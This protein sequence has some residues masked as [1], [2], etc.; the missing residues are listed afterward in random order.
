MATKKAVKERRFR[1]REQ[2]RKHFEGPMRAFIQEKYSLIYEEYKA[3]YQVLCQNH[4]ETR[5]LTKTCT[6]KTWVSSLKH[7]QPSN[8]LAT[9]LRQALGQEEVP[10]SDGQQS[11]DQ[12]TDQQSDDESTGQQSTNNENVASN[13][14]GQ[15]IQYVTITNRER[16][17]ETGE[18]T[19]VILSINELAN[20][21]ENVE[22]QVDG[23]ME[24]LARDEALANVLN[25]PVDEPVDEGI[26]LDPLDDIDLDLDVE[27][28]DF[29][30]EVESCDW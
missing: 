28:F 12:S 29:S 20:L 11:N 19:N 13:P 22:A 1:K 2:E 14:P 3:F 7:Q 18:A 21:M 8:I 26:Q 30:L 15:D 17:L 4:P 5:D 10:P 16:E 25:R 23:I 9:A 24:E 6:F 27:P